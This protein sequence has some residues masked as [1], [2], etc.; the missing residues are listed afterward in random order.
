MRDAV[1][2][3]LAAYRPSDPGQEELRAQFLAAARAG[4]LSREDEPD[5][6]T[7]SAVVLD[8][9]RRQVLLVLHKKVRLWLQPGGHCDPEDD[10]LAQAALREAVEET[11]VPDL[12]LASDL[13]VHLDRHI[14]PCGARYHLDVRFLVTAPEDAGVAVSE[15]SEDVRWWPVDALPELRS[16]DLPAMLAAALRA[17]G[18]PSS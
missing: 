9:S 5:H 8:P 2:A 4:A 6:L 18:R 7:G 15:E 12:V 17:D 14:A 1:V 10:R 3:E 13:P 16:A 11:G